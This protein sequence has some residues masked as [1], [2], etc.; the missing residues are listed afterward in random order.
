MKQLSLTLILILLSASQ[1]IFGADRKWNFHL[2]N[3]KTYDVVKGDNKVYFLSDGGVYYY[4]EEDNSVTTITKK[5]QLSGANFGGIEYSIVT[6]KLVIYYENSVVD[7]WA[8]NEVYTFNDISRKSISGNKLI[9]GATCYEDLCYLACGFGIVVLDLANMEIKDS[10]IIGDQGDYQPVYD[11]AIAHNNIYA[12]TP[13]G[14]KFASLDAPNL[15]D[16][17]YWSYVDHPLVA[18]QHFEVLESGNNKLWALNKGDASAASMIYV[19]GSPDEWTQAFDHLKNVRNIRVNNDKVAVCIY[20]TY[21]YND[22]GQRLLAANDYP[23]KT[24]TVGVNAHAALLDDEGALW[25]ADMNFGGIRVK[26]GQYDLL[27]PQGPFNNNA[28]SLAYSNNKLWV[29][30]GGYDGA[31]SNLWHDALVMSYGGGKWTHF[32]KVTHEE[33][34]PIR[35]VVQ[36]L[37]FPGDPNHVFIASWGGGII[38]MNQGEI[39]NIYNESNSS[40][41]QIYDGYSTRVGGMD[42]DKEGNLWLTNSEVE[43]VLH[44]KKPDNSWTAYSLPEIANNY[45]IGA[46]LITSHDQI[47]ITVP[48]DATRGIYVMSLDGSKKKHL[49]V[50]SYF[51]NGIDEVFTK[52]N[53]VYDIAEDRNG[54]IW[55]GTS[56]GL[57]VYSDPQNV[58]DENPYY[59]KQPGLNQNDGLYHPVLR[60]EMVSALAIDGGN[61][62]WCGTLSSGIYL[63]SADGTEELAHFTAE[64]SELISNVILDLEYN[65]DN[66][67]LYIATDL[68]LI[69]YG[70]ESKN[71]FRQFTDV[72]AYPNP[73]HSGYEGNI[74]ITGMMENTNVKIT[75]ISGRLVYE[76]TS[77]GGQ[78]I[79]DG[80]DLAGKRVHTGVYLVFCASEEG[81]ESTVTKIAFIR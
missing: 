37:P 76:T 1:L 45:K 72:Y 31:W 21:V 50:T 69:S 10:F 34:S 8:D 59:A 12:S 78:A 53:D 36:V 73:V 3:V 39:I 55:V 30:G 46:P 80:R 77:L 51:Y 28:F 81:E 44:K 6:N 65:G 13:E 66:G 63:I 4:N 58:F 29:A 41:K 16:Y 33:F 23:F 74:Y 27:T 47:W 35:D 79:W 26:D 9:Y 25:I 57:I 48:R 18:G 22:A 14:I 64:N 24:E 5:D 68:G 20:G 42:F 61:R 15:L 32:N 17:T 67:E 75:N 52:M 54:E 40:L 60:K 43:N 56:K 38:E 62:K 70:T 71:S 11:V 49:D 7:V 19:G 2:S